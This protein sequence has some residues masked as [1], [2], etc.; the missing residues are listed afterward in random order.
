MVV[1]VRGGLLCVCGWSETLR[2]C[3]WFFN[4]YPRPGAGCSVG[5]RFFLSCSMIVEAEIIQQVFLP[6]CVGL[7]FLLFPLVFLAFVAILSEWLYFR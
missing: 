1:L 2:C 7:Y 3:V 6:V 4:C 5:G